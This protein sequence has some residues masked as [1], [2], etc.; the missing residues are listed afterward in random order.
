MGILYNKQFT[1]EIKPVTITQNTP[2]QYIDLQE[3]SLIAWRDIVLKHL[4][5]NANLSTVESELRLEYLHFDYLI[6]SRTV[7]PSSAIPVYGR[8][9]SDNE[10][11]IKTLEFKNKYN[12]NLG[13]AFEF[14]LLKFYDID[15]VINTTGYQNDIP[16]NEDLGYPIADMIYNNRLPGFIDLVPY[17]IKNG[18]A[19]YGDIKQELVLQVFP[20][21][22]TGDL[23]VVG[24]GY[25]GSVT[26]EL[27]P[28][29]LVVTKSKM[30]TINN[31][32]SFILPFNPKRVSFYLCN[33]GN[34]DI[35][36]NFGNYPGDNAAKLILKPGST[37]V[38]EN[39]TLLIDN[40][41][42][43]TGDKRPIFNSQLWVKNTIVGNTQVSI[44]E[45]SIV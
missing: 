9:E 26:F 25:S 8:R 2:S 20:K 17:L 37:L 24:G 12:H 27:S 10:K 40:A 5:S 36:Y 32:Y 29:E 13:Y 41:T 23:I 22:S 31:N 38:Y 45:L 30:I 1:G 7:V 15:Y 39:E 3:I 6:P 19:V 28:N 16:Y 4:P 14:R 21:L 42:I 35:I 11:V 44:E 18:S 43:N 33:S 34:S